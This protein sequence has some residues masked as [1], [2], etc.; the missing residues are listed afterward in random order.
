MITRP[1]VLDLWPKQAPHS[2]GLSGPEIYQEGKVG[3]VTQAKLM[4]YLPDPE[5]AYGSA[6]LIFPGGGFHALNLESMGTVFAEWLANRGFTGIVVKYRMPNGNPE[7]IMEDA[8]QAMKV[9]REYEEEW[10]IRPDKW[11]VCGFSIGGNTA[12]WLCNQSD[13]TIRPNFQILFYPVE[14]MKDDFTHVPTRQNFLGAD[15][16]SEIIALH[17]NE[18]HVTAKVPPTFIAL[19]DNDPVVPQISTLKYFSALK[20]NHVPACM[21][22]FPNGGHGWTFD[23][24]FEYLEMCKELLLKWL[25]E[26]VP[27]L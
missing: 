6:V 15:P 7:I 24:S 27:V 19:S 20:K 9:A 16:T 2:N 18:L 8:L 1:I 14:S 10:N 26:Q 22:I 17:S 23:S 4:V 13:D 25:K 21:Y 5:K 11:G 12:S 3:H